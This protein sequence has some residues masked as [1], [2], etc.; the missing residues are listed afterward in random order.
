MGGDVGVVYGLTAIKPRALAA[1]REGTIIAVWQ[2]VAVWRLKG[3]M[4]NAIAPPDQTGLAREIAPLSNRLVADRG[5]AQAMVQADV[6]FA[7]MAGLATAAAAFE[8]FAAPNAVVIGGGPARVSNGMDAASG[9]DR[10][11]PHGWW[12]P[13]AAPLRTRQ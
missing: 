10:E 5:G 9:W 8:S 13:A 4:V 7:A 3:L 12:Q 6:D 11:V 1:A 2:R